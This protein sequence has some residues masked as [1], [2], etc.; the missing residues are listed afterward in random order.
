MGRTCDSFASVTVNWLGSLPMDKIGHHANNHP[1]HA[2]FSFLAC[3]SREGISIASHVADDSS[4][5]SRGGD[6]YAE[7]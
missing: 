6:Y 2:R 4:R 5:L 3:S 1:L 7:R